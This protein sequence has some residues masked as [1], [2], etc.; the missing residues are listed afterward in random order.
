MVLKE[1]QDRINALEIRNEALNDKLKAID[2]KADDV[3]YNLTHAIN[4][5]EVLKK[6]VAARLA[7]F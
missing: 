7:K 4:K 1:L 3:N 2:S 5:L 6:T